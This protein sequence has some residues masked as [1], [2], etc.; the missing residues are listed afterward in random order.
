MM[1]S[2]YDRFLLMGAS[3]DTNKGDSDEKMKIFRDKFSSVL[4][5]LIEIFEHMD[6]RFEFPS[7]TMMLKMKDFQKSPSQNPKPRLP[8]LTHQ[9]F[10]T[11][12]R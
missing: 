8:S 5:K 10:E 7:Q 9:V 12:H 1:S 6:I 2:L 3:V 4:D 11:Q